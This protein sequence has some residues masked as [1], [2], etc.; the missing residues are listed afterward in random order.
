MS[1]YQANATTK[2]DVHNNLPERSIQSPKREARSPL[3]HT[4]VSKSKSKRNKHNKPKNGSETNRTETKTTLSWWT[5]KRHSP[6]LRQPPPPRRRRRK[7]IL[8]WLCCSRSASHSF[9]L[10]LRSTRD[11]RCT[12]ARALL[13]AYIPSVSKVRVPTILRK[14]IVTRVVAGIPVKRWV[15]AGTARRRNVLRRVTMCKVW[16]VLAIINVVVR[17]M[18]SWTIEMLWVIGVT[19][20]GIIGSRTTLVMMMS[21]V[22]VCFNTIP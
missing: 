14:I 21:L 12:V 13:V 15:I 8:R 20:W 1:S 19:P 6:A 16:V 10:A 9:L 4:I 2:T 17:V 7:D 18:V 22:L 5:K 11:N 3:T